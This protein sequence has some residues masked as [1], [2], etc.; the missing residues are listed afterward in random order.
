MTQQ[1]TLTATV[2]TNWRTQTTICRVRVGNAGI[3]HN[4]VEVQKDSTDQRC[5]LIAINKALESVEV[6]SEV[7]IL[8]AFPLG[9]AKKIGSV[10]HEHKLRLVTTAAARNISLLYRPLGVE[11]AR[12]LA[13]DS[14][15]GFLPS[16]RSRPRQGWLGGC[17]AR[18]RMW[19]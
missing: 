2:S 8:L 16:P 1:Y 13:A 15:E 17:T 7:T 5:T 14:S 19:G 3:T 18:L 9:T 11:E 12:S 4:H 10:N 6:G